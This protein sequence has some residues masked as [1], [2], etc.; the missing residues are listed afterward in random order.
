VFFRVKKHTNANVKTAM[1][2][3]LLAKKKAQ[4]IK[5]KNT[6]KVYQTGVQRVI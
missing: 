2:H 5:Q 6:A 1:E 4:G 3:T